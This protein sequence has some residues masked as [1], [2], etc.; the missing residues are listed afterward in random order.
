MKRLS[1]LCWALLLLCTQ[2]LPQTTRHKKE[3]N[4]SIYGR[5]VDSFTH[6]C[7]LDAKITIMNSDS[8][9]VDTCRTVTWNKEAIHPDAYFY[10]RKKL[11][12]DT[13]IFKIEHPDYQ[14]TYINH[15]LLFKGRQSSIALD[16]MPIQRK[17]MEDK[18][19]TLDEVVVKSTKIKM[20]MKGDTLVFPREVCSTR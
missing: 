17:R 4:V 12:E 18:E 11:S 16:D 1:I 20:V 6:L 15:E 8:V 14:T 13:Y 19:H 3:R 7:V 2:A 5:V 9:M 10:L